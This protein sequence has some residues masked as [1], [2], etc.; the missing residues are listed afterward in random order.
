MGYLLYFFWCF[1]GRF[2]LWSTYGEGCL[3]L[4]RFCLGV[5]V[6]FLIFFWVNVVSGLIM[7]FQI[8]IFGIFWVEFVMWKSDF[9]SKLAFKRLYYFFVF[10]GYLLC[11]LWV[12]INC[13]LYNL[14]ICN[15]LNF[16]FGT[17]R[18]GGLLIW[19]CLLKNMFYNMFFYCCYLNKKLL[20][21]NVKNKMKNCSIFLP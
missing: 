2:I 8:E 5:I 12:V 17:R 13:Y 3:K 4:G 16:V 15:V 1:V 6:F 9:W 20:L 14:L 11:L 21:C 18:C 19:N 7:C 10:G